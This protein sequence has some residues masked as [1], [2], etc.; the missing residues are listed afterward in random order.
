MADRMSDEDMAA[1]M[2]VCPEVAVPKGG[3]VFHAGAPA[4]HL[5][6]L[7]AGHVKL[8]ALLPDGRERIVALCGPGD[9]FGEAFLSD[10][11]TYRVDAVAM[12]DV[13]TCPMSLGDYRKLAVVSPGF[14][15]A[16]TRLLADRLFSC[17]DQLST[18]EAPVRARV[19]A[20]FLDQARRYGRDAG[21]GWLEL[22]TELRHDDV[23]AAVAA[24]RV[25]IT[26]ALAILRSD[27]LVRGTRGRYL[28]HER[29][30]AEVVALVG[31]TT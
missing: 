2:R 18:V 15:L 8:M 31:G 14:V 21:D 24:T 23:A 26:S 9:M 13:T 27:G 25:S 19:A 12:T 4:T 22:R 11:A 30:L 3:F 20:L 29:G 17:R 5:H 7:A 1:F 16:F 28:L 6:V 10:G